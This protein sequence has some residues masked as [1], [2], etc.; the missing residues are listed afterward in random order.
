[1]VSNSRQAVEALVMQMQ[2]DF[3]RSPALKLT[4]EDAE[5][6]LRVDRATCE[7]ILGALVEAR[8]LARTRE[9]TYAR[10]FPRLARVA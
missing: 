5:Q 3:L 6:R 8:V 2:D 4:A 7:A 1:M 9:G 10:F